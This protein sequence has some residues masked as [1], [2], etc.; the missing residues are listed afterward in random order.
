MLEVDAVNLLAQ[1]RFFQTMKLYYFPVAPNPTKVL[2]YLRE[3][4]I[5]I[6]LQQV[7]LG[8]GEQNESEHLA[9]NP[10]GAL[11]VLELDD[12][13]FVTESLPIIEY[14][15]ECYPEPVM[16][17]ETPEQR[18]RTREMERLADLRVLLPIGR[19]VHAT[20]SPLGKPPNPA[21]AE[22]EQATLQVGFKTFSEQLAD[23][24]FV[25]GGRVTTA[26]CTLFAGLYFG[27]FFG[28]NV[29]EEFAALRDWYERF[30]QRPSAQL[31]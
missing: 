26:D 17:G 23:R 19:T 18:V 3:K 11:P 24:E 8:E 12:G 14:L 6:E 1:R 7:S 5:E 29:P 2:V 16:I 9:R 20:N 13:S 27:E 22:N 28:V 10:R 21:V 25:M 31:M 30:K 4:G 15:E